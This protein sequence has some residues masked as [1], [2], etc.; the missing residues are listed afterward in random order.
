MRHND[1]IHWYGE[2]SCFLSWW[3]PSDFD[4]GMV[5]RCSTCTAGVD[6]E[7]FEAYKQ[8]HKTK[9]PNCYGTTFEGGLRK[10]L[11][12]PA[13]W[14]LTPIK[15]SLER[16]GEVEQ[17]RG[18]IQ[19]LSNIDLYEGDVVV[20]RDGTR[21]RMEQPYWQEITTGFGSQQGNA[22]ERLRGRS[23]IT[24]AEAEADPS[25]LVNVS[26]DALS[27]VGY[28]PYV[29]H[30]SH[31]LDQH[32][33]TP[34]PSELVRG[35]DYTFTCTITDELGSPIDVTGYALHAEF[36]IGNPDGV[37]IYSTQPDIPPGLSGVVNFTLPGDVTETLYPAAEA[38]YVRVILDQETEGPM[39]IIN[40][41]Q[42][43]VYQP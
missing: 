7:I 28:R 35:Q 17:I 9:C 30:T 6:A 31:P 1:A 24:L 12:R 42:I 13:I 43:L 32:N 18:T 14:D 10:L 22:S 11:Y 39:V 27:L 20:R 19:T 15:H 33:D 34:P 16:R 41:A 2:M 26:M 8:P 37:L 5:D 36:R 21:W 25:Y 23:N 40:G 38:V 29:P 3:R 4:A